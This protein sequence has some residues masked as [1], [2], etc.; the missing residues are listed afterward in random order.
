M[1]NRPSGKS[2]FHEAT[3]DLLFDRSGMRLM[4]LA[5]AKTKVY[6]VTHSHRVCSVRSVIATMTTAY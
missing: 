6:V 3:I 4:K 1:E 5:T 2:T